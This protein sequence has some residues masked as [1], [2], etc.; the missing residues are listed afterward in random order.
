MDVTT[1]DGVVLLEGTVPT[2]A[3]RER[4][5]AIAQE[6]TGVTQVVDRLQVQ[7]KSDVRRAPRK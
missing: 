5:I 6:T 3:A 7:A 2:Q 4:A 1:K